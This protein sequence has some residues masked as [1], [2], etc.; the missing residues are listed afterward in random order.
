MVTV[1]ECMAIGGPGNLS[2]PLSVSF[3]LSVCVSLPLFLPPPG[4]TCLCVQPLQPQGEGVSVAIDGEA[5]AL[6]HHFLSM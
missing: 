6:G 1:V 2:P 4:N 5:W 3:S